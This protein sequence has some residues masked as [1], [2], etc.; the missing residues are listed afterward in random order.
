MTLGK[1]R[2]P[3]DFVYPREVLTTKAC[4]FCSGNESR[5]PPEI[6]AF[7][8]GG[9]APNQPGAGPGMRNRDC[10]SHLRHVPRARIDTVQHEPRIR[11]E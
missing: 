5:T 4:P 1:G 3:Q 8:P 9:S 11:R 2:W 7:R 6:Y 10:T